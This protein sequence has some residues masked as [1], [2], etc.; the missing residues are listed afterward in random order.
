[1]S[2]SPNP[3][4][5]K[6]PLIELRGLIRRFTS[7]DEELT[8]LHGIDLTIRR[9]EMVAIIGTSGSGKSTLMNIIGCLDRPSGGQYLYDGQDV[10]ALDEAGRARLRRAHF[11]F[12]FQRYQLLPDLDAISNVEVPAVYAGAGRGER[13]LRARDLLQR[14]GLG[15]RLDH[16]PNALSGGQQQRV[17]VARALMNGGEV[18]LADE[19]TGALDSRSGQEL[20]TLLDELHAAGHTIIIVTHDRE[21]AARAGR[22]IEMR[23]GQVIADTINRAPPPEP[24]PP[25]ATPEGHGLF[26]RLGR[27]RE[28]WAMAFSALKAHPM[29]SF[30]TM[31]GIIIG[32]ASVVSVVA[33]GT[34]SREKVLEQIS[35]LGT[36]TVT[37]R[38]GSGFGDRRADAVRSLVSADADA[39]AAAPFAVSVSP[40]ISS[41]G[42][43]SR[44]AVS[45]TASVTGVGP[46]FFDAEGLRLSRGSL[47]NRHQVA[48]AAQ[49]VVLNE[50]AVKTFF[51]GGEN[52]LGQSL[53]LDRMPAEVIGVIADDGFG[54]SSPRFFVPHTTVTKRINGQ[55]WAHEIL[56]RFRDDIPRAEAEAAIE[57][58]LIRRHGKK[59]FFMTSS[60]AMQ[61]SLDATTRTLTM[62]ISSIAVISLVVGG[63][64]VMNIMLASVTERTREIGVRMAVGARRSDIVAQ[65]LMEAVAV[66]LTG[67]LIGIALAL[68]GG[69][70]MGVLQEEIRLSYSTAAVL[71]ACLSSSVIGIAF[72]Y[73]PA[74]AAA[75]LDPVV[76]LARD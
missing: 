66:C 2:V 31:L 38:P 71:I 40:E 69:A 5:P 50:A 32:I 74:R 35:A 56:V 13:R 29:R 73:L 25:A 44:G 59:D 33:L 45:M 64:G 61:E 55:N 36:N 34:G 48:T 11:G 12:I 65:F 67:G 52:P 60:A 22:V 27:V 24:A 17:S 28:A 75:R 1:M 6:P 43:A 19:P 57:E 3:P 14:L 21:V 4:P 42:L 39:I 7:G 37:V 18:I 58:L 46:E 20:L 15:Q 26:A 53:R 76:A 10:G 8:V 41:S 63:I 49:V 62:L 23:D 30:L 51:P 70:V 16:R 9:G 54:A 47:L 68:G 72:G